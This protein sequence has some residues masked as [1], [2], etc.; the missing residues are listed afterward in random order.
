MFCS[1]FYGYEFIMMVMLKASD[2]FILGDVKSN[3]G[4]HREPP[5]VP[6]HIRWFCM[7]PHLPIKAKAKGIR[8]S[9]FPSRLPHNEAFLSL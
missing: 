8:R 1:Y 7:F 9:I 4:S 6:T 3:V 2:V 5:H